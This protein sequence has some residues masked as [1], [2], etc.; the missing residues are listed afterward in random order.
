MNKQGQFEMLYKDIE[1]TIK[2][3]EGGWTIRDGVLEVETIV[4]RDPSRSRNG[5][6][7]FHWR[8]FRPDGIGGVCAGGAWSAEFDY[9]RYNG[10]DT[11]QYDCIVSLDGLKRMAQMADLTIAARAWLAKAPGCMAR[12][13]Q[14]VRSL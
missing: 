8:E 10:D 11:A 13:K 2:N 3:A 12:L 14:A 1:D 7:Y 9:E 5:G 6:E 4:S